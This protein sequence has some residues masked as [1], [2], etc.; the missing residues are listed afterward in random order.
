MQIQHN[1]E[2][3]EKFS[4]DD[5]SVALNP[6]GMIRVLSAK[7]GKV[8]V[9]FKPNIVTQR[10]RLFALEKIYNKGI[11]LKTYGS[12]AINADIIGNTEKFTTDT[13]VSSNP[14]FSGNDPYTNI[15]NPILSLD[16]SIFSFCIGN[17]GTPTGEPFTPIKPTPRDIQLAKTIPFLEV[18]NPLTTPSISSTGQTFTSEHIKKYVKRANSQTNSHLYYAKRIESARYAINT[19]TNDIYRKLEMYIDSYECRAK[20]INELGL[21]IAQVPRYATSDILDKS[22]YYDLSHYDETYN[23]GG[24]LTSPYNGTFH[25]ANNFA[26]YSRVTFPSIPLQDDDS[27]KIEYYTYA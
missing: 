11:T 26:L 12:Q 15:E 2:I 27:L 7:T 9:G 6:G 17:G 22:G 10:G 19:T 5:E 24:D 13:L 25:Q 23:Y 1:Q 20:F 18:L 21:L 14:I 16:R 3:F 8:L 4:L